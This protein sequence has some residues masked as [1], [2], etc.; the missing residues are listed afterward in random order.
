MNNITFT[1]FLDR[2]ESDKDV[3]TLGEIYIRDVPR[4]SFN[5]GTALDEMA[6]KATNGAVTGVNM[7]SPD[8]TDWADNKLLEN[9]W[10]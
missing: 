3:A 6:S 8:L 2:L 9:R 10:K 5:V 4:I 1:R 7:G